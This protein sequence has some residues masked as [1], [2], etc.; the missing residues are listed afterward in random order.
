[1]K[2]NDRKYKEFKLELKTDTWKSF[3]TERLFSKFENGKTNQQ[4]LTDGDD[5]FYVG[6]KRDDNGIMLHCAKDGTL[7]TKGN[8][9]VFICN[10]QGSV[11][12]A[13]YM[14]V[15]FMGTT[16]IVA[17]YNDNLNQY[18]GLFLA[19]IYSLERPK[20][21]FGRKWKTHLKT[22]IVSLPVKHNS[23]G[24]V[25]IDKTH[26]YSDEGYVP[27][28]KFMENYIKSLYHKPLTTINKSGN[29]SSLNVE[30][31]K[32]FR[33]S[34]LFNVELSTGDIKEDEVDAG[35]IPLV[36]SGE[37][38]NGI[39]K[40]ITAA[41]DGKAMIFSGN[42]ITLDMFGN[43]YYQAEPFYAVS[44]GRVNILSSK[45][46]LNQYIGLFV[47][48]IIKREQFKYSYGRAV[49]SSVAGN[50]I[51]KLPIKHNSDGSVFI[52]ETHKY[53]DEGFVP[54]WEFMENYIKA[55]PYGDRLD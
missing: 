46:I 16:D 20:Y 48:S 15:D 8:C 54:D 42:K 26:K 43:A 55:L 6:A 24:S 28:W 7:L 39:V 25:F 23:D 22:T 51:I 37:T 3:I 35:N 1:M 52:D 12:Y 53:S 38:N 30:N 14:D 18:T 31:W 34:N 36:S 19:T 41:G 50:M 9:I 32:E 11:G 5:C 49:Y 29:V 40:H 33:I 10:G 2:L 44:H 4:M 17:G 27:D 13:N 47:T 45:F 21:S